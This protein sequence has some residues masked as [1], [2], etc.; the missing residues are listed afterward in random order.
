MPDHLP[1]EVVARHPVAH[2]LIGGRRQVEVPEQRTFNRHRPL[3]SALRL[4]QAGRGEG[5]E[6]D[7]EKGEAR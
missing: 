1:H 2:P 6:V 5:G 7:A 4:G 3:A